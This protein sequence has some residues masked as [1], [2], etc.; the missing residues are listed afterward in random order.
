MELEEQIGKHSKLIQGRI[1]SIGYPNRLT[2]LPNI[3]IKGKP[4][5]VGEI[6]TWSD[7]QKM[8]KTGEG[9][10]P[11]QEKKKEKKK[12]DREPTKK[13]PTTNKPNGNKE[14]HPT[15]KKNLENHAK[16]ASHESLINY[17]HQGTDVK[18]KEVAA[19]ALKQKLKK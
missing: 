1:E 10:R 6:R 12:E 17:L 11:H 5:Q 18:V 8:I 16:K 2:L 14:L 9:W 13:E 19:N 7:G 4:A 15:A 3:F